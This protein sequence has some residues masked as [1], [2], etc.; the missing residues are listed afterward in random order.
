[1]LFFYGGSWDYG[2]AGFP[3]YDGAFDE[4]IYEGLNDKA[5]IMS[6]NYRLNVFGFLASDAL[7]A[8]GPDGSVG[9]YGLQDQRQGMRFARKVAA[10]FGGDP[11]RLTIFGES[12]GAGSCSNHLVSPRSFGLFNQ[13]IMESGPFADWT[14]I[15]YNLSIGRWNKVTTNAGCIISDPTAQVAC[16]RNLTWQELFSAN[17]GISS[18]FIEWAP[19]IDGVEVVGTPRDLAAAGQLAPGVPV[20]L[21]FNRNEGTLLLTSVKSDINNSQFLPALVEVVGPTL[22]PAI[23]TQYNPANYSG[24]GFASDAW[25]ALTA[26]LGDSQMIC[27]GVRSARNL[28]SASRAGGPGT[29][30]VYYFNHEWYILTIV[31]LFRSLG[32]CHGS[33]LIGVFGLTIAGWGDGEVALINQMVRYWANFATT[34]DPN[35][36]TIP[37]NPVNMTEPLWPAFDAAT[38]TV[39]VLDTGAAGVNITSLQNIKQ[40][41]CAFWDVTRIPPQYVFN[42]PT[43]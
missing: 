11:N 33:E 30:H 37:P 18:G 31:D 13:A 29:A 17:H 16:M 19:V 35:L 26:V 41:L 27:A 42:G 36:D 5:I 24:P 15:P 20:M 25:W 43:N 34:G 10:S 1:M 14:A 6:V 4:A 39:A 3:L 8:D 40:E 2:S 12:A 38:N 32:V 28:V 9:N 21:G 7:R 23:A 22:A